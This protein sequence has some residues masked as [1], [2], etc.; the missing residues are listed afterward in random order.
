V[1]QPPWFGWALS[2]RAEPLVKRGVRFDYTRVQGS[3]PFLCGRLDLA[4]QL[5]KAPSRLHQFESHHDVFVPDRLENRLQRR[6]LDQVALSATSPP[7]W[8]LA[9][10]LRSLFR[11]VPPSDN[12]QGDFRAWRNERLMAHYGAVR[13][14][15]ELV[16]HRRM[17]YSLVGQWHGISL[18]F[19][20]EKLFERFVAGWLNQN[21]ASDVKVRTQAAT[22]YLCFQQGERIFRLEPDILLESATRRWVLDTKWKRLDG[23]DRAN[24]YGLSQADIYQLFAYGMKYLGKAGGDL[25]L[26][27]PRTRRFQEPLPPFDLG[28][29]LV[30]HVLPF[31]L[32]REEL[33]GFIQASIPLRSHL[34]AHQ[35]AVAA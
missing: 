19:P 24:N 25:A 33:D 14:W 35:R 26:V 5:R 23:A 20:M 18:L 1:C 15:C 9:Q 8:R 12:V 10:E 11:A 27:F 22:E 28:H 6:A 29:N 30:L 4:R 2:R 17:P 32:F 21:V 34:R 7:N 16:L 31:D 3:E 13:P